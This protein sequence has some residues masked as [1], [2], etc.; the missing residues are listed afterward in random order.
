MT[1]RRLVK[2]KYVVHGLSN[3]RDE[4]PM[5]LEDGAVAI[6][7]NTIIAID[8]SSRFKESEFD[9]VDDMGAQLVMPGLVNTHSHAGMTLFRGYA[10]DLSLYDW[11]NN[12]IWP[13]EAKTTAED[14]RVGAKL[15]AIEALMSGTTTFNSMY[16]NVREEATSFRE[17]GV[18]LLC[19]PGILTGIAALDISEAQSLIT[20]LHGKEDDMTRISINPHAPYTVSSEDYQ[21]ITEFVRVQNSKNDDRPDIVVHTHLH[22]VLSE[23]DQIRDFAKREGFSIPS[24]INTPTEYMDSIGALHNRIFV[25]HAIGCSAGDIEI[26][27]LRGTGVSINSVSNMKLANSFAPVTEY[28]DSGVKIGLGTDSATSNNN[29]DMF[30]EMK[31]TAIIQKGYRGNPIRPKAWEVL[32]MATFYGAQCM[33]WESVG[34]LRPGMHADLISIDLNKPHL[35]PITSDNALISH[36]VYAAQGQ[37]VSNTMV[38]GEWRMRDRRLI[39][40][41]LENFLNRFDMVAT[42]LI[43]RAREK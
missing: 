19:G 22:E 33:S 20:D 38:N 39:G 23:M 43:L 32:K 2:A 4:P 16:W 24:E 40:I 21:K 14:V 1:E 11:L 8:K 42:D 28:Y 35:R 7:G 6:E 30:E 31:T 3:Q 41:D 10:D 15:A 17:V 37:D 29:L 18:R 26:L 5:V 12:Y 34:D 27:K 9:Y 13:I 36:I 25:A